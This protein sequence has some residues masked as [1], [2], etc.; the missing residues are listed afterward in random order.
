MSGDP[1]SK[2]K[3]MVAAVGERVAGVVGAVV[4]IAFF[5]PTG[6]L[7]PAVLVVCGAVVGLFVFGSS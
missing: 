3:V 1:E 7:N 4:V 5:G 6:L 2:V